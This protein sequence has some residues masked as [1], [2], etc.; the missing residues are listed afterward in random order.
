[1]IRTALEFIQKELDAYMVNRE[2]DPAYVINNVVD[3]KPIVLPNGNVNLTESTHITIMLTGVEEERRE[4]KRPHFIPIDNQHFAKL[5]A[6]VELDLFL[7]FAAH[8]NDYPT[9][10]RD[11]SNVVS[12]FQANSVFDEQKFPNLNGSV[13]NPV[14]TPWRLIERL[15]FKCHNMTFEQQNNLWAMLGGKYIPSVV[16]KMNM[17][18]VFDTKAKA[19]APAISELNFNEAN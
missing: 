17:L 10:L 11:L 14:I 18:T 19:V 6:P 16:Y 1:M 13:L 15:S 8:N 3:L 12:F 9:A 5:N 7:L 2:Q 4:G